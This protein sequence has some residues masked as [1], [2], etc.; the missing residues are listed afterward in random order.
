[1]MKGSN[2]TVFKRT[3][4]FF[5]SMII[6]VSCI[7]DNIHSAFAA[8][9]QSAADAVSEVIENI[10]DEETAPTEE[11]FLEHQTI[12]ASP[13]DDN[14]DIVTLDGLMPSNATVNVS[15]IDSTL[16]ENLCAYNISIT[17]N[18]GSEY[19]PENGNTIKVDITSTNIGE[20]VSS[21]SKLRLWHIDDT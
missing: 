15:S 19:Q 9:V 2:S 17:D 8:E 13:S 18:R 20:A 11:V 7:P 10:E 3:V 14:N 4:G 21:D 6:M 16:S 5:M 1:M 12:S